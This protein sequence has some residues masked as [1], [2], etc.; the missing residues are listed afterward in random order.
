[1]KLDLSNYARILDRVDDRG[2]GMLEKLVH[3]SNINSGSDNP[4]GLL[5]VYEEIRRAFSVLDVEIKTVMVNGNTS[6]LLHIVSERPG[7]KKRI[8]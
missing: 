2:A 8:L 7:A 1:M 6:A 3:W 4:E 5:R